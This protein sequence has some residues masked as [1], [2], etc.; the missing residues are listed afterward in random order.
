MHSSRRSNWVIRD[1]YCT[2]LSY[3]L[4]GIE[5]FHAAGDK[6]YGVKRGIPLL[7]LNFL[8]GNRVRSGDLSGAVELL[9]L[10]TKRPLAI[11]A[12]YL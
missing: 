6:R 7:T 9:V 4:D 5:Q 11:L 1:P 3:G 8:L 10:A 12:G 2:Y